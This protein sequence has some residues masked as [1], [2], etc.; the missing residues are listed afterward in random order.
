MQRHRDGIPSPVVPAPA[1][2]VA[3]FDRVVGGL[4]S[5]RRPVVVGSCLF[6]R[7]LHG[8]CVR[9]DL[10]LFLRRFHCVLVSTGT[11]VW[12]IEVEIE[13]EWPMLLLVEQ[14]QQAQLM[15]ETPETGSGRYYR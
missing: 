9:R 3:D 10:L 6:R 12:I 1:W 15:L 11:A 5:R 7:D 8:L 4:P 13:T 2:P 14:Q